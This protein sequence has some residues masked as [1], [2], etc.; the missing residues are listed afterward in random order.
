MTTVTRSRVVDIG[1]S[2]RSLPGNAGGGP[3]KRADFDNLD[4]DVD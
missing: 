3:H 2:I 1:S 4:P